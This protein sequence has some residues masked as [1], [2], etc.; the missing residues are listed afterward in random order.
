MGYEKSRMCAH[1]FRGMASSILN[2]KGVNRDWIE[3][4]LA[5][6]PMDKVR[7]AY[8]HT[9]F[10]DGRRKMMQEWANWLYGLKDGAAPP[11]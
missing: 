8:L 11:A 10:L 1:G 6:A 2:E 9:E 7:A 3:R 5:H 4:Q